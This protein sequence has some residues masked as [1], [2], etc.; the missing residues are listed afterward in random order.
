MKKRRRFARRHSPA[1]A[2]LVPIRSR[3]ALL[4]T[5]SRKTVSTKNELFDSRGVN[6]FN[7]FALRRGNHEYKPLPPFRERQRTGVEIT[8]NKLILKMS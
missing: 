3:R 7:T 1:V 8:K 6:C 5:E 4:P 2:I